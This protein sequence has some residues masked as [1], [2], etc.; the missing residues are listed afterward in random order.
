[1]NITQF[2]DLENKK[3][4]KKLIA[5]IIPKNEENKKNYLIDKEGNILEKSKEGEYL[6][7][8]GDDYVIIT[9]FDVQHPELRIYGH[10]SYIFNDNKILNEKSDINNYRNKIKRNNNYIQ[11]NFGN[12][13]N[14]NK[15][16]I[17]IDDISDNN[18]FLENLKERH[19]NKNINNNYNINN[20]FLNNSNENSLINRK[21]VRYY[22]S[23]NSNSLSFIKENDDYKRL[24][25]VWRKRYGNKNSLNNSKNELKN[26][27]YSFRHQDK[28]VERTN[29][30][31]KRAE[32]G[33][34]DNTLMTDINN[35]ISQI[36]YTKQ[37]PRLTISNKYN[38]PVYYNGLSNRK[39]E[40]PLLK[41]YSSS[42]S[43]N[44][45]LKNK[46]V[47]LRNK[48]K[49]IHTNRM[50]T[51]NLLNGNDLNKNKNYIN[52]TYNYNSIN[53][54][55]NKNQIRDNLLKNLIQKN[56]PKE[57]DININTQEKKNSIIND[58][59]YKN[60]TKINKENIKKK[61]LN[62][63]YSIL[64]NEANKAIKDFNSKQ[65]EKGKMNNKGNILINRTFNNNN[66]DNKYNN[67]EYKDY[68]GN[69]L[70]K[71]N[72]NNNYIKIKKELN[73]K[74][75]S[76]PTSRP[77]SGINKLRNK[78]NEILNFDYNKE[79]KIKNNRSNIYEI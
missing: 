52:Y 40:N 3:T 67:L 68:F 43:N 73:N 55:D 8:N 59:I 32:K 62:K 63:K 69:N 77:F 12:Y 74:N 9:D 11:N 65:R 79:K 38:I 61:F 56:K 72:D 2:I 16:K 76:K 14:L 39:Y 66:F 34:K 1:M 4:K 17:K 37:Y 54:N 10:R 48:I 57:Y 31:L 15:N 30:I 41:R 64:S 28:M 29:S 49:D 19:I 6:C 53:E 33:N 75:N 24:M 20:N 46:N 22:N 60:I 47:L 70:R 50:N 7:K 45:L 51:D 13:K 25:N 58:Y 27:S 26:Y 36:S 44:P 23:N 5:F 21:I 18:N 35:D 71:N 78:K 42:Y